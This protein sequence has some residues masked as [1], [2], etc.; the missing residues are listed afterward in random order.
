MKRFYVLAVLMLLGSPAYAGESFSFVFGGHHIHIETS[1]NCRSASCVSVS[2]PGVYEKRAHSNRYDDDDTRTTPPAQVAAPVVASSSRPQAQSSPPPVAPV[3]CVP[4]AAPVRPVAPPVI[5]AAQPQAQP[6]PIQQAAIVAALSPQPVPAVITPTPAPAAP[7]P[8]PAAARP[9]DA[10]LPTPA[11]APPKISKVV[12]RAEPEPDSPLGD[13]QTEGHKGM[14]RIEPCGQALC[15]YV[16]D[17]ATNTKGE[18]VLIDMKS[19]ASAEWS[20]NIYSRDSGNTYYATMSLKN[21]DQLQ[22]EACALGRFFCSGNAWSRI[23]KSDRVITYREISN[24]PR[25]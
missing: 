11:I 21:P 24:A 19:K 14:V 25:S 5:A 1:R 22:V 10:A 15:G 2:I 16:L 7:P 9:A 12:H 6:Q 8:P 18:T 3:A 13:W 4:A 20:G 17:P 23:A